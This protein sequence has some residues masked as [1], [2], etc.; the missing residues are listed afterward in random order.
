MPAASI[1]S[2]R[3]AYGTRRLWSVVPSCAVELAL[4][5][6]IQSGLLS[7]LIDDRPLPSTCPRYEAARHAAVS[8]TRTEPLKC[9]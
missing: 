3:E 8:D 4:V 5:L 9:S 1:S 6:T 2:S 7:R